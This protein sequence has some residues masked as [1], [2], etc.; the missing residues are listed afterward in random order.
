MH[1]AM[2][3]AI[4]TL[5]MAAPS[6]YTQTNVPA[7]SRVRV[8]MRDGHH[9]IGRLTD[10]RADTLVVIDDGLI[11]DSKYHIPGNQVR[12]I[13]VSREKYVSAG[14]VVGGALVGAVAGYVAAFLVPGLA[15]QC[16]ADVCESGSGLA[17]AILVGIGAGVT[18]GYLTPADRWEAVPSPVRVGLGGDATHARVGILIAF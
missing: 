6:V 8:E 2:L 10:V 12:R 14:R 1:R 11:L 7:N 3:A 9:V 5:L 17:A 4:A 13:D 16:S 15:Q 18:L